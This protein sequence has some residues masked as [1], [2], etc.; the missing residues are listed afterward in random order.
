MHPLSR[1]VIEEDLIEDTLGLSDDEG[2]PR[3]RHSY[4]AES[5]T[6]C[7]SR[8][9]LGSST[10]SEQEMDSDGEQPLEGQQLIDSLQDD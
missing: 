2:A 9:T 10:D 4:M 8:D 1:P 7:T 6:E 5:I 3:P